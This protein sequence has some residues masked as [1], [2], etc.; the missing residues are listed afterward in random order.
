MRRP[1]NN[2]TKQFVIKS[3]TPKMKKSDSGLGA[4]TGQKGPLE[5]IQYNS[6][7]IVRKKNTIAYGNP[8]AIGNSSPFNAGFGNDVI[9]FYLGARQSFS[10]QSFISYNKTVS[11]TRG[12]KDLWKGTKFFISTPR[13]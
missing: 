11:I 1:N 7:R 5:N 4:E 13:T 8:H 6:E 3:H 2:S 12:T 10:S 9:I